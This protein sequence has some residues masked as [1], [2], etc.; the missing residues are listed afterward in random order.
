MKLNATEE[1]LSM[2]NSKGRNLS[3]TYLIEHTF[4]F[5]EEEKC[6]HLWMNSHLEKCLLVR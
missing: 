3:D 5:D 1:I 6:S 2:L 4:H